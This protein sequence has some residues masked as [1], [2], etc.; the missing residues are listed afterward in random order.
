[1]TRALRAGA[2]VVLRNADI[3]S[4]GD[5]LWIEDGRIAPPSRNAFPID[6]SGHAVLPGLINAHDHL[7]LNNVPRLPHDAPF[8]SS[9][10]WIDAMKAHRVTPGV[11]AAVGVP[12]M[13]R[14]WHG[15]LKNVLAGVTTVAHHDPLHVAHDDP[16]FP[17]DVVRRFGWSH[18]LGLGLPRGNEPPRYGPSV[19]ESFVATTPNDPWIIHLAEGT[20][21][22]SRAELAELNALGCLR[23]NTVVVHGTA[24]SPNDVDCIIAVGASVV[25]CP[26]SNVELFGR[27]LAPRSLANAGRLALGT[28]SRLTGSRDILEELG[29]AACH[30]DLLPTELLELVTTNPAR[31]LR[32][33]DRGSLDENKRADCVIIR[34][35]KPRAE[36][37]LETPRASIRAVIRGGAPVIADPDFAEWF[38][39][40]GVETVAA[41]LDGR[42]KLVARIIAHL[43]AA[44][45][46]PGFSIDGC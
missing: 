10:D 23:S 15:G 5:S 6:L 29:V 31:V 44:R 22:V 21:D 16:G 42:P 36:A 26:S 4:A 13:T 35:D 24:L 7:Q 37:L 3:G 30:S 41:T 20:D 34:A 18:S 9:Y 32:L 14:H 1:M 2:P 25:W 12:R 19:Q 8:A 43:D 33:D 40:C 28:D 38:E 17:V 27:T 46:E 45:L 11:Q 39:Y